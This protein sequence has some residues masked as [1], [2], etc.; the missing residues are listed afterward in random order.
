MSSIP[1]TRGT[2]DRL[3]EG[4]RVS[5]ATLSLA[6]R[7]ERRRN[8]RRCSPLRPLRHLCASDSDPISTR[9]ERNDK[10]EDP[11]GR[12]REA[13]SRRR[14][15]L[16]LSGAGLVFSTAASSALAS[17]F[18]PP[19]PPPP[20]LSSASSLDSIRSAYDSYSS[21]Y[22]SLDGGALADLLGF[23][24][25]RKKAVCSARGRVLE[26]AAG[27]GLSLPLY[28]NDAG[29]VEEDSSSSS[30]VTSLTAVD[31]SPGMLSVARKRI[32][33]LG[34]GTRRR[35]RGSSSSPSPR[36]PPPVLVAA[37]AASLPFADSA[38]D[39]VVDTFSLCVFPEPL[40][41]LR[42]ARRVLEKTK[43][44]LVLVE[45]SRVSSNRA[46]ALYQDVTAGLIASSKGGGKGCV[47]NQ[48]VP[49]LL[50]EA[51]FEVEVEERVAGGTV[52]LFVCRVAVN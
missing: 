27:T 33:D 12:I 48:D 14:R 16:L 5:Q 37:D 17:A 13:N 18:P 24:R 20:P 3:L 28:Y 21:D 46:L 36:L 19:P 31:L 1:S 23:T 26:L 42:E 11:A 8:H 50:R 49:K 9:E 52:G 4:G 40:R 39:T 7:G 38:F 44:K 25:L 32:E 35:G 45:H 30:V 10:E 51:G 15:T 41:A 6:L 2:G 22:D 47:W 43:G 34:L 29:D